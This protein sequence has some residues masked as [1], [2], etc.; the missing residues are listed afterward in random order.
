MTVAIPVYG[1]TFGWGTAEGTY[2]DIAEVTNLVIPEVQQDYI[3]V[4]NSDSPNGFR[5]YIPGLK[6]GGEF[7]IE[8]NYS[9][10]MMTLA[11]GYNTNSTLIYFET[12]LPAADDQ[13]TGDVFTWAAYVRPSVPQAAIDEEVKLVLNL[14][15]SGEV[16]HTEGTAA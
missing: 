4:T 9:H 15:V 16:V 14:R 10:A 2:T 6:D 5:E 3:E 1:S 13:S 7:G 8:L 12:V 11:Y